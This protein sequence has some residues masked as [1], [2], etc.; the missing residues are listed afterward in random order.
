MF[1]KEIN[2]PILNPALEVGTDT[3]KVEAWA[4]SLVKIA[5]DISWPIYADTE[6]PDLEWSIWDDEHAVFVFW[7]KY[8]SD[9][10]N[11][12]VTVKSE[13]LPKTSKFR[14]WD[15]PTLTDEYAILWFVL[16]IN[17]SWSDFVGWTSWLDDSWITTIFVN[18]FGFVWY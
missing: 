1:E 12:F 13:N 18:N 10:A 6:M 15:I 3:T 16:V 14:T 4:F 9:W 7:V 2:C 5:W 17:E 11:E 8:D